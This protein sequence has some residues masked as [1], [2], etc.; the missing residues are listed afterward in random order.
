M[1][2]AHDRKSEQLKAHV[3]SFERNIAVLTS[4]LEKNYEVGQRTVQANNRLAE[5]MRQASYDEPSS[6]LQGAYNGVAAALDSIEEQRQTIV[7]SS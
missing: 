6:S 5:K 1:A 4:E 3:E 7:V 2:D